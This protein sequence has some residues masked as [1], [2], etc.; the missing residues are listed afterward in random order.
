MNLQGKGTKIVFVR[1]YIA[2]AEWQEDAYVHFTQANRLQWGDIRRSAALSR[3]I[4][5]QCCC[6]HTPT[7]DQ[8]SYFFMVWRISQQLIQKELSW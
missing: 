4:S 7:I 6:L 3:A 1:S 8:T 2:F 5:G